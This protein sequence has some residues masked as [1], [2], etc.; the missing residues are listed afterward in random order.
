MTFK[1]MIPLDRAFGA[2][3]L[4]LR[5]PPALLGGVA[6]FTPRVD[7]KETEAEFVFSVSVP[8]V[9]KKDLHVDLRNDEVTI[10]GERKLDTDYENDEGVH[11]IEQGYGSFSRT[12]TLPTVINTKEA[13]ASY[14]DGVLKIC[15]PKTSES[16]KQRLEI[17]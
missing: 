10:R 17:Q 3:P 5:N 1:D 11:R 7:V 4:A 15:L 13:K 8:G 16:Q 9:E 2:W 12:F 6:G 14:K